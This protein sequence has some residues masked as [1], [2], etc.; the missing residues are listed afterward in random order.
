MA[1]KTPP[2]Q[3][4]AD[5]L[6]FASG[7]SLACCILLGAE[8]GA[9]DYRMGFSLGYGGGGIQIQQNLSPDSTV[10]LLYTVKRAQGPGVVSLFV[11]QMI[12]DR[13]GVSL[14]HFRAFTLAPFSSKVHFTGVAGRYYI[15]PALSAPVEA[16]GDTVM[17][18][19]R[20]AFFGG[21]ATGIA[22][23]TVVLEDDQIPEV[24]SSG[25]YFGA[26]LGAD[27]A[28]SNRVALRSEVTYAMT[29]LS[30]G[31]NPSNMLL[32]GA[33]VGVFFFL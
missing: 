4:L 5:T 19:R 27:Y 13:F 11:D 16:S 28:L 26:K 15:T 9:S 7:A 33:N 2:K 25:I 22:L 18:V 8:A 10:P 30:Q 3:R 14:E 29:L 1:I 32:F 17:R 24:S 21:L 6:R 23:G 20:F 12:D 31:K